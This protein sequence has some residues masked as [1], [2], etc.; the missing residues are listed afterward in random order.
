MRELLAGAAAVLMP[1]RYDE[2]SPYS[3][4]E[5]MAQGVPVVATA[6]GGLPD[7][8]GPGRCVPAGDVSAFAARLA[9]LWAD[10][11]WRRTEGQELLERARERHSR[12]P[13]VR[14]LLDL[15]ARPVGQ[16][17]DRAAPVGARGGQRLERRCHTEERHPAQHQ[18]QVAAAQGGV[19]LERVEGV[20]RAH[21]GPREQRH[22]HGRGVVLPH[23]VRRSGPGAARRPR[24]GGPARAG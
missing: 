6:M 17:G 23:H 22:P 7:L 20:G 19:A 24:P 21:P 5:A 11:R 16:R 10:P 3:A 9:A 8:L 1:S 15:Y 12:E 4:L 13:Y 18:R 2:F 14:D